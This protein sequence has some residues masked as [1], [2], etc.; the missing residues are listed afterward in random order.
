MEQ[1]LK[2][3]EAELESTVLQ[4]TATLRKLA[5]HLESVREEEKRA[6]ARELHDDMGAALTSLSMYLASVYQMLPSD[7]SWQDKAHKIQELVRSLVAT[8]RRIQIELRPIMLDLFGL[9]A[10]ITELMEEFAQ[11]TGI[12]CKTSLPDEECA[13]D[14]KLDITIYRMLQEALNNVAKHA[15]AKHVDVILDIDEDRIALTIRDDGI[16]IADDR[17][18]NQSTYGIRGL[19]ER[20]TFLGGTAKVVAEGNTGTTVNITLPTEL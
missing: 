12:V 1:Q 3:R 18:H 20:A 13:L 9:K 11:R 4:R 6:I 7:A 2:E 16:G 19:S 8:T 10:G 17:L 5:D 14:G 15:Q